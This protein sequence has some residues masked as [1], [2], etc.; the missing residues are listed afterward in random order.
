[1]VLNSKFPV[2]PYLGEFI[3]PTIVTVNGCVTS[4]APIGIYMILADDPNVAVFKLGYG[5]YIY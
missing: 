4:Q 1:M 5:A 3:I 2:P